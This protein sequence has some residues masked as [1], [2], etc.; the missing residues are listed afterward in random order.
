[1]L[2]GLFCWGCGCGGLTG[3]WRLRSV[4]IPRLERQLREGERVSMAE[5]NRNEGPAGH[6][7]LFRRQGT[8][9]R[10]SRP[11]CEVSWRKARAVAMLMAMGHPVAVAVALAVVS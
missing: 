3:F 8:S 6:F 11:I 7:L 9:V 1:M 5:A 2:T 4:E 10:T